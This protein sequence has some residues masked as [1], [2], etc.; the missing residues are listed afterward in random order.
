MATSD[1]F[2]QAQS[3]LAVL[4]S[5]LSGQLSGS[6]APP[7]HSYT[8]PPRNTDEAIEQMTHA[9]H[10]MIRENPRRKHFTFYE[11]YRPIINTYPVERDPAYFTW[12][13][14]RE[15]V[16]QVGL[17]YKSDQ[18]WSLVDGFTYAQVPTSEA[19]P[20]EI[21]LSSVIL[22]EEHKQS[23]M[24]ALSQHTY[25]DK[26]FNAWGFGDIL[27][28]GR[29]ISLLFWGPPGT[30]KTLTAQTIAKEL[31]YDL[32]IIQ[33]ADIETAEPGGAERAIRALF[34]NA[35]RLWKSE[36]PEVLLFDECDSLLYDRTVVGPILAAQ[37]NA[38]LTEIEKYE[39]LV[40]FTTNRLGR[41]DPALERRISL[42]L[43]IPFPDEEQ[44][45]KIWRHLIPERCPLHEGVVFSELAK[46]EI[47][48]G[49]I[50]N[51]I[52]SAAR[53]AAY[54]KQDHITMD[55][56]L[57]GVALETQSMTQFEK[58]YDPGV[59]PSLDKTRDSGA[60]KKPI[61]SSLF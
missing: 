41:L 42:K 48:G 53:R 11:H 16:K 43:E 15:A 26:L 4:Q 12:G 55:D 49:N 17:E 37:V 22:P 24:E 35:Q 54:R 34:E 59:R 27:E 7:T 19:P 36:T 46:H 33:T 61:S 30:G 9:L 45:A 14:L 5:G 10:R 32:K 52:L 8:N 20:K 2:S 58:Q 51:A 6:A 57:Y 3:A 29:A 23:I 13:N 50:K 44:R 38:L 25:Y 39:G 56:F 18:E 28:K 40:F 47:A 31:G 60:T 21:S 1:P